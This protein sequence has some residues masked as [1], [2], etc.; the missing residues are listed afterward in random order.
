MIEYLKNILPELKEFSKEIDTLSKLQN[1]P[2]VIVTEKENFIKLIFRD[3]NRLIVSIDGIVSNGSWELFSTANSILL[4]FHNQRRLYNKSF[5]DDA[6]IILKLDGIGE[7]FFILAN[8]ARIPDLNI[9]EYL[10]SKYLKKYSNKLGGSDRRRIKY[11]EEI[12]L[13]NGLT[14]Q[15]FKFNGYTGFTKVEINGS[16]AKDGFYLSKDKKKL[17]EIRNGA[18]KMKFTMKK[19]TQNNDKIFEYYQPDNGN[20]KRGTPV[21]LDGKVAPNGKYRIGF[22]SSIKVWNGRI[23]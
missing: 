1:Q 14:L 19:A 21:F 12:Q 17:F 4:E 8:Q 20:P 13:T 6:L 15:I 11:Q 3:S 7:S 5:L 2:W 22:L 23:K 16:N 18:L 9:E 10:K